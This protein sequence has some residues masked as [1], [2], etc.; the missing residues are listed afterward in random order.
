MGASVAA[1]GCSTQE[2]P[3]SCFPKWKRL[4][5]V[6][7]NG[8]LVDATLHDL[9]SFIPTQWLSGDETKEPIASPPACPC[10]CPC[11]SSP[12]PFL[13]I[14]ELGQRK[15]R[16][17]AMLSETQKQGPSWLLRWPSSYLGELQSWWQSYGH[18]KAILVCRITS[19]IRDMLAKDPTCLRTGRNWETEMQKIQSQSTLHM[20]GP[21]SQAQKICI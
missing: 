11:L 17:N 1:S 18:L 16:G 13:Q 8:S 21:S 5:E 19:G 15:W 10:P 3:R 12:C 2:E 6:W 7:K 4:S 9:P 14:S 20:M